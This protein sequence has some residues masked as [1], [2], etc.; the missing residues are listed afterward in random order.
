MVLVALAAPAI[1]GLAALAVEGGYAY[2]QHAA[3]QSVSDLAALSAAEAVTRDGNAANLA[4]EAR[5]IAAQHG[6]VNNVGNVTVAVNSP[7]A[8]R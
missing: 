2:S 1:V 3:M 8:S 7:P 6:F 5:A 4:L